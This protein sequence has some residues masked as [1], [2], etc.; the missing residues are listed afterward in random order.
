MLRSRPAPDRIKGSRSTTPTSLIPTISPLAL[1]K[2]HVTLLRQPD[3]IPR[4]QKRL[5][6]VS[7]ICARSLLHP[8]FREPGDV[9]Y[10]LHTYTQGHGH[11]QT[12]THTHTSPPA[13][14]RRVCTCIY[15]ASSQHPDIDSPSATPVRA[16]GIDTFDDDEFNPLH[17]SSETID[18]SRITDTGV[19]EVPV[20]VSEIVY[21]TSN[22]T[23]RPFDHTQLAAGVKPSLRRFV[24]RVWTLNPDAHESACNSAT[25]KSVSEY[26]SVVG[27]GDD[28]D[29]C[30]EITCSNLALRKHRH[31]VVHSKKPYTGFVKDTRARH[32]QDRSHSRTR[33]STGPLLIAEWDLNMCDLEVIAPC[34][35]QHMCRSHATDVFNNLIFQP[36][37]LIFQL[38]TD[39]TIPGSQKCVGYYT[40]VDQWPYNLQPAHVLERAPRTYITHDSKDW[41]NAD[42]D[43]D[44]GTHDSGRTTASKAIDMPHANDRRGEG[45][46]SDT[47]TGAAPSPTDSGARVSGNKELVVDNKTGKHGQTRV[48]A[49]PGTRTSDRGMQST[50]SLSSASV[51][52]KKGTHSR[53]SSH[54]NSGSR[55]GDQLSPNLGASGRGRVRTCASYSADSFSRVRS[56]CDESRQSRRNVADLESRMLRLMHKRVSTS[57]REA[58]HSR[59]CS[60]ARARSNTGT[61]AHV[62]AGTTSTTSPTHTPMYIDAQHT[63]A[64][65]SRSSHGLTGTGTHANTTHTHQGSS[66]CLRRLETTRMNIA[67]L[68][69]SLELASA[70]LQSDKHAKYLVENECKLVRKRLRT[71]REVHRRNCSA[72]QTYIRE[73]EAV[74]WENTCVDA[75]IGVRRQ[76]LVRQ[77]SEIY[78][79]H[80]LQGGVYRIASVVLPS[81]PDISAGGDDER[82]ATALGFA[83]HFLVVLARLLAVP[84]RYPI[85]LKGSR[86]AIL[87][88]TTP[89]GPQTFPLYG[90]KVDRAA[91]HRGVT[92]L[93]W[94]CYQIMAIAGVSGFDMRDVLKNIQRLVIAVSHS[95]VLAG[96]NK[97]ERDEPSMIL[98]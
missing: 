98:C 88:H 62:H 15:S 86:S 7:G 30:Q 61:H 43:R 19:C 55:D 67:H 60:N 1:N 69:H 2:V 46:S 53:A 57:P 70:G 47:E 20:Y 59:T 35:P 75:L 6:H 41:F 39:K 89:L 26:R 18:E 44:G 85:H 28:G 91:Y 21:R 11:T 90:T 51:K 22:P 48:R 16:S 65:P 77:I 4:Q 92:L 71:G 74:V 93:N 94:D 10:T 49:G 79:V 80:R 33:N 73:T 8:L 81:I 76:R 37:T 24:V 45:R 29:G 3:S 12:D 66:T 83:A 95:N 14:P 27:D 50:R 40:T 9:Y 38:D 84:L 82:A 42:K 5:R 31:C 96:L 72:L 25:H 56:L 17:D 63:H 97:L 13:R 64:H 87:Q 68:T 52:G 36:N 34:V 58:R 23:W 78:P 54:T 32:E